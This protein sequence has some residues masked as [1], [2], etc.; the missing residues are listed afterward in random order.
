MGGERISLEREVAFSA[1]SARI[2]LRG[3]LAGLAA[4]SAQGALMLAAPELAVPVALDCDAEPRED[5][6]SLTIRA[7]ASEGVFPTFVG[8]I[9]A[10]AAGPAATRVRLDGVY[11]VPLGPLGALANRAGL[12]RVAEASL[13]GFLD[14]VVAE[15]ENHVRREG[16]RAYRDARGA[17]W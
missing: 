12:H 6:F 9:A 3:V 11:R 1:A 17:D 16:D 2:A 7:R 10:S 5:R 4:R 13:A 14:Q 8:T 15:T